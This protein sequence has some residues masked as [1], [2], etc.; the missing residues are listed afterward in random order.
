MIASTTTRTNPTAA[1]ALLGVAVAWG[2]SFPI[3]KELLV[4]LPVADY[5]AVR[6]ALAFVA[7]WAFR[8]RSLFLLNRRQLTVGV[9]LGLL[10]GVGQYLQ[11]AGLSRA[12]VT[13]SAF[14]VSMYVVVVPLFSAAVHRTRL[15]RSA[16]LAVVLAVAG[17]MA[18]SLR[19][20][21]FGPGESLVLTSSLLYAGHIIVTGRLVRAGEA[22]AVTLV[23]MGTISVACA[24]VG[25]PDGI[26]MPQGG[27]WWSMGYLA[28]VCG[29][30]AMVVQAWSQARITLT[31]ASVV[32]VTEPVWASVFAV[33]LWSESLD[34][35]TVVG[36]A[37]VLAAAAL[38]LTDRRHPVPVTD[39]LPVQPSP[40]TLPSSEESS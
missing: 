21:S 39:P 9:L 17:V 37:L 11:F 38:V 2:T 3:S 4:H 31:Q 12:P 1:L 5:L 28:L 35:R 23:Q 33:V 34:L 27:Q 22:H 30:L 13:V 6:F 7:V 25:A 36:A 26:T 29:G 19:G 18:M 10:Y 16:A 14:L 40:I 32:M 24:L 8:P 15:T 20:W